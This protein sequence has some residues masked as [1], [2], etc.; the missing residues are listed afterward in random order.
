MCNVAI[1]GNTTRKAAILYTHCY[2]WVLIVVLVLY[3]H[4][5]FIHAVLSNVALSSTAIVNGCVTSMQ[6]DTHNHR[7]DHSSP[8]PFSAFTSTSQ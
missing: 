5:M 7:Y 3:I 8:S 6:G 2:K 1:R 4:V